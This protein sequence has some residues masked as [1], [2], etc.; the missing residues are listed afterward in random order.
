MT[1]TWYPHNRVCELVEAARQ[2][3]ER[4]KEKA[5]ESGAAYANANTKHHAELDRA[6]RLERLADTLAGKAVDLEDRARAAEAR[7]ERAE[8]ECRDR[9]ATEADVRARLADAEKALARVR[10]LADDE[11]RHLIR[12]IDSSHLVDLDD[13]RAALDGGR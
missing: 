5:Q 8:A 1:G 7:A 11:R 2:E 9:D 3:A 6:N 13:L 12:W 4:W 10:E